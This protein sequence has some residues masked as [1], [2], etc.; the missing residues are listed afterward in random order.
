MADQER[1]EIEQL[2]HDAASLPPADRAAYLDAHCQDPEV[3]GEVEKLLQYD[4][5]QSGGLTELSEPPEKPSTISGPSAASD[6]QYDSLSASHGQFVP[7]TILAD[8]Y[9]VVSLLG[10]GGMGEVYRADDLILKEP[11]ALKILPRDLKGR[12]TLLDAL[13]NE[14]KQ[15][16][17]V[18]HRHVCRVHDIG[19]IDGRTFLS[20]EWIEGENLASLLHRIGRLPVAKSNQLAIQL[21]AGLEAA[22][23]EQVLHLDLK[24][25]NLMI[26]RHGNLKIADFGLAR[27]N[28]TNDDSGAIAGTPG[29]MAPEQA[30][31]NSLTTAADIFAFGLILYEMTTGHKAIEARTLWQARAF[32]TESKLITPP[33][34]HIRDI[35]SSLESLILHCLQQRIEDR[36][37]SMAAVH[38]RLLKITR[39]PNVLFEQSDEID[40]DSSIEDSDVYLC[41][42]HV[43]DRSPSEK[44]SGWITQFQRNLQIRVEQLS[45]KQTRVFRAPRATDDVPPDTQ[46]LSDLPTVKAMVSVISPPFVNSSGCINEV[47]AFWETNQREGRLHADG[48]TR[49]LK[50]VK[51]PVDDEAMPPELGDK[52]GDLLGFDF[53][54]YDSQTGRLREFAEWFG[55]EAEQRFHERVYDVAQ[56]DHPAFL[57]H[58]RSVVLVLQPEYVTAAGRDAIEAY[59]AGG[60]RLAVFGNEAWLYQSRRDGDRYSVY[61]RSEWL[62]DPYAIDGDPGNDDEIAY[63]WV[64]GTPVSNTVGPNRPETRF[65][66]QST[67][68]GYDAQHPYWSASRAQHWLFDGTGLA[69]GDPFRDG[70]SGGRALKLTQILGGVRTL[71]QNGFP[72]VDHAATYEIPDDVLV[73]ATIPSPHARLWDCSPYWTSSYATCGGTGT[74][75]ITIRKAPGAGAILVIPD[76]NWPLEVPDDT[77]AA[78]IT[79]NVL[80]RF[81]GAASV[82]AYDGYAT[83]PAPNAVPVGGGGALLVVLLATGARR[84]QR[85]RGKST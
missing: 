5:L 75:A 29:Y 59:V 61:K 60:G 8:R 17:Q 83:Q 32:H 54:E 25:A 67:W 23:A 47:N 41:F 26:D 42:A 2:F 55:T 9:R 85:Q 22:H 3:R 7:G 12:E 16:R 4:E 18:S 30:L 14:V 11:I 46:I 84:A 48:H 43:D 53:F 71:W 70:N 34:E 36:P 37:E 82:D 58:F 1:T 72:Y 20:M 77:L 21:A 81:G 15:A 33:R 40:L 79:D 19:E 78:R 52:L 62:V 50:V 57:T 28:S 64:R 68:L 24:P 6:K 45:G 44:R 38:E 69:E 10:R 65:L 56:E 27:I 39:G 80:F 74:A 51:T 76:R 73:L 31:G 13:R 49:V 35:S 63:E 66:G